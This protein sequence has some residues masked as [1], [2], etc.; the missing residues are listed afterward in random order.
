M[1]RLTV[2]LCL[3]LAT[4][5]LSAQ[6]PEFMHSFGGKYLFY[7]NSDGVT[8]GALLYS[9]R[10]NLSSGGN[11]TFSVGTHL[12]L[13]F[14]AQSGA[15]GSSSS[16]ILDLPL[17]AEYN[18][19]FGATKDAEG[20][21]GGYMGAGYGIHRVSMQTDYYSGKASVHGPVFTGGVRFLVNPIGAFDI[22]ASYSL[23]L[24]IK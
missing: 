9:P 3:V 14:S 11:N 1:R 7:S 5:S 21:F 6:G 16:F 17:V 20:G 19:G 2:M 22:G 24:K 18:V 13:G 4:Y 15:G 10:V 12:A 23:D 8:G